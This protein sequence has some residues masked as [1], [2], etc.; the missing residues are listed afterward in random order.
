MKR[1][2]VSPSKLVRMTVRS[3]DSE[4]LIYQLRQHGGSCQIGNAIA[5]E[6]LRRVMPRRVWAFGK[7]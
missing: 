4:E 3:A 2:R 1:K 7:P 5:R 6:L